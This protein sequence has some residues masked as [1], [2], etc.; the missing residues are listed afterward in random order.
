VTIVLAAFH[1]LRRSAHT[2]TGLGPWPSLAKSSG[3]GGLVNFGQRFPMEIAHVL[4]VQSESTKD[5][6]GHDDQS[7]NFG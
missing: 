6:F 3:T 5:L 7:F 4:S 2:L 1:A